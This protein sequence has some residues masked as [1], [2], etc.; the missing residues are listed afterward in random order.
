MARSKAPIFAQQPLCAISVNSTGSDFWYYPREKSKVNKALLLIH[1]YETLSINVYDF[2]RL[3]SANHSL[4]G[5]DRLISIYS[6]CSR[7]KYH[8]T[9]NITYILYFTWVIQHKRKL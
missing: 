9:I 3:K 2:S 7:V 6:V 1:I 4:D 8:N 5:C